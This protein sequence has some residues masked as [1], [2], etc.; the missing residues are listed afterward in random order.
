VEGINLSNNYGHAL[1]Y[2]YIHI[3]DENWIKVA[4]LYYDGLSRI[5]PENYITNDFEIV[6]SL[7]DEFDFIKRIHPENEAEDIAKDFLKFAHDKLS[8][9]VQRNKITNK[10]GMKLPN[11][12]KFGIHMDKMHARLHYELPEL[13]LAK[14]S[15]I[16]SNFYEF[17]PVTGA[18]YMTCLA[19]RMAEKRGIPIVSDN[20][21]Y[22]PLIRGFQSIV[23]ESEQKFDTEH[24]LASF[25]IKNVIPK[26]IGS[27]TIK[28]IIK[29]RKKHDDERIRFYEAI[30]DL[31]TKIPNIEDIN[32][33]NDC[34]KHYNK[35]IDVAVK[36]LKFGLKKVGIGCVTGLTGLSIPS[37]TTT[38]SQILPEYGSQI[39]ILSSICAGIGVLL[40]S[41]MNYYISRKLSPWSYI[42]SLERNLDSL[43][44]LKNQIKIT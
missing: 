11:D 40:K 23:D 20:P 36:E 44:F 2:P 9:P 21:V 8:D 30:S 19:N 1:Y 29:F 7:N 39:V 18:L 42:L 13:G 28:Q 22:Q 31:V 41:R 37:W 35:K 15:S 10:I 25:A 14:K 17:E 12:S 38:F 6:K 4:A 43:Q 27:V 16:S 3:Q 24:A 26:K 5:V 32:A 34:L 33:L